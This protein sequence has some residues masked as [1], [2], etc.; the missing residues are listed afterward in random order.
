ME[1][2]EFIYLSETG[3]HKHVADVVLNV[4]H[5]VRFAVADNRNT[6]AVDQ[7]FLEVPAN[8][9]CPQ[10]VVHQKVFLG[11]IDGRRWTVRLQASTRYLSKYIHIFYSR[12]RYRKIHVTSNL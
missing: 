3:C 8:V 12:L 4:V 1:W 10:V 2:G 11:E 5:G 6:A 9:V 7:E